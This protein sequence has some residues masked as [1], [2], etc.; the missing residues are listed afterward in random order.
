MTN[1]N[2]L[3]KGNRVVVR[4]GE[5]F[6]LGEFLSINSIKKTITVKCDDG[7]TNSFGFE[8]FVGMASKERN[9][10][11]LSESQ[12]K[13]YLV[14]EQA[15]PV[16]PEFD[17]SE[18]QEGDRVMLRYKNATYNTAVVTGLSYDKSG[19]LN[20]V[21]VILDSGSEDEVV[22]RFVVGRATDRK[23]KNKVPH[24]KVLSYIADENGNPLQAPAASNLPNSGLA[25]ARH[26]E[27]LARLEKVEGL[28]LR[29]LGEEKEPKK[30]PSS[31]KKVDR[32]IEIDEV[33]SRPSK[34][35]EVEESTSK[36]SRKKR[37]EID[38]SEF[39]DE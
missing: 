36:P 10:E 2:S 18:L 11:E 39:D 9:Q 14:K 1:I 19:D 35:R 26:A 22:P 15:E 38:I 13:K 12:A 33:V 34:K 27:V 8:E 20:E 30:E 32:D 29:L 5:S 25:E 4:S 37:E 24:D 3:K 6:F 21:A 17:P 16:L 28:L 31:H 7:D 23:S